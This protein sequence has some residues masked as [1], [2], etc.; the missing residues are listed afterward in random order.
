MIHIRMTRKFLFLLLFCLCSLTSSAVDFS[1][2]ARWITA[3]QGEVNAPNTWIAFRRDVT[4]DAVPSEV[5]A[6]IAA[7]SKY[8]LWVNGRM[9]VFEG[10][11]K[12]G[13]TPRDSYF[14]VVDLAPY[15][16][17]GT[18]QIALLLWYFGKSGFSHT[19]SGK[20]G[21]IFSAPAI[22]LHSDAS[23]MSRIHPAYG[24]CGDPKPNYR[25]SESSIRFD[26]AQDMPQ[27]QTDTELNAF[28]R[29]TELGRAG[30]APWNRLVKRPI[31]LWR[32]YGLK[33]I[34]YSTRAG[35]EEDT[36]VASHPSPD[37]PSLRERRSQRAR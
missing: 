31:P 23:W 16:R 14:D 12:R 10:S 13:P 20:S 35:A 30:D 15:L 25:L 3:S 11:V 4:L 28:G 33:D 17:S 6:S 8:W 24:T 21:L 22:G 19:D 34:K 7:D 37:G 29:S 36:L 5:Q 2:G 1:E 9:I 18:N 26:A 27:W 32:D